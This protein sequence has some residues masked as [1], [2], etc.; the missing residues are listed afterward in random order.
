MLCNMAVAQTA[1]SSDTLHVYANLLQIPV[2]VL[3]A[4]RKPLPQVDAG[5]F[6]VALNSDP[7]FAPKHVRIEGNDPVELSVLVDGNDTRAKFLAAVPEA[8]A[9]LARTSLRPQD[10]LSIFAMDGCKLRRVRASGPA[11]VDDVQRAAD[12]MAAELRA[13][14]EARQKSR[15]PCAN[16]VHLWDAMAWITHHLADEPGRRVLVAI[17]DGHDGG[18]TFTPEQVQTIANHAGVAIF[19]IGERGELELG[20]M[21][22]GGSIFA[23]FSGPPLVSVLAEMSGGMTLESTVYM[24]PATL[25]RTVTLIRGRYIV[26]FA[27]PIDMKPMTKYVIHV[28]DGRPRDFIRPSGASPRVATTDELSAEAERR[29]LAEHGTEAGPTTQ[30][31]ARR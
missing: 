10:R 5:H 22:K 12:T 31:E 9:T 20:P 15:V 13:S 6:A 27:R 11:D 25:E 28:T 21:V 2:L 8:L 14:A 23:T 3:G 30:P 29:K 7:P 4:D 1:E 18:S 16:A 26:E 24:L 17:T 19:H